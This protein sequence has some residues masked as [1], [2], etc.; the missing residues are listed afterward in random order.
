MRVQLWA[1]K[2]QL[3]D[4]ARLLCCMTNDE[5]D[6]G[7]TNMMEMLRIAGSPAWY[8][9]Q[10][11]PIPPKQDIWDGISRNLVPEIALTSLLRDLFPL[12]LDNPL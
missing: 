6:M 8:R 5:K 4:K 10:Q 12:L 7:C 2:L 9:R 1:S 3:E 11:L